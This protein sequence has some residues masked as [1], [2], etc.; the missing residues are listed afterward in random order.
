MTMQDHI[1]TALREQLSCWEDLLAEMSE[2]RITT[3]QLHSDWTTKDEIAHVWSWL[4]VSLAR[5]E[6]AARDK[7]PVFPEAPPQFDLATENDVDGINAWF[8][9]TYRDQPWSSIYRGWR[10]GFL[11]LLNLGEMITERDLLDSSK[12]PWMN[13]HPLASVLLASYDHHQEHL[14]GLREWLN[15]HGNTKISP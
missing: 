1:L 12:Y 4:Q 9:G 5:M 2:E 13:D 6:A 3:A 10:E 15:E 14:D 7:E 8:H 11:H